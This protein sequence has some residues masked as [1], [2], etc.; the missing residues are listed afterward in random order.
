MKHIPLKILFLLMLLPP[1]C[2]VVTLQILEG[3]LQRQVTTRVNR[4]MIRND[5]ALYE[6]RYPVQDEINRNIGEF[7]GRW[8]LYRLGVRVHILVKTRDNRI[9]YP[10]RLNNLMQGPDTGDRFSETPEKS[11]NFVETAAE[12]YRI[13]NNGLTLSVDLRIRHNSWLSNGILVL[14]VAAALW[15]LQWMIKKRVRETER[16]E[17]E[18]KNRIRDL[19]S[20]LAEAEARLEDTGRKERQYREKIDRINEE[21]KGLARDIEGF[22]EEMEDLEAGVK[23]QKSLR[24]EM[25]L[26][27]LQLEEELDRVKA[28]LAKPK[29]RKKKTVATRKRFKV[30]YKNLVFTD[31]AVEGFVSLSDDFQLKAEETIHR[32][33]E[34]DA[35]VSVK[36]KVFGKGGKLPVLES[37]FSYSG[38]IYFKKDSRSKAMIVAIGTKNTQEKDLTFIENMD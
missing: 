12:N 28:K 13:L 16:E 32:L 27:V 34:D 8:P 36:R 15:L 5:K 4:T 24:E 22:L 14:Y 9:L 29:Q 20:R 18:Q 23:G 30:L 38:R 2:Y 19:S 26:E 3:Y 31:R 25:E 1:I 6:G 21:K 10:L 17:A 11:L 7:L 35:Q 33:N 37:D